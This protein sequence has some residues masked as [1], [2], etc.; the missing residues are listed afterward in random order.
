MANRTK[1]ARIMDALRFLGPVR[2]RFVGSTY[3]GGWMSD[4]GSYMSNYN[5]VTANSER[6]CS[7]I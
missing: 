6:H 2:C 7:K 1:A 4:H 5:H 3:L